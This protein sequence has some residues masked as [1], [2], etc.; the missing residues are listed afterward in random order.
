MSVRDRLNFTPRA[1]MRASWSTCEYT[2]GRF[3]GV[4]KEAGDDDSWL[5]HCERALGHC[6]ATRK[7]ALACARERIAKEIRGHPERLG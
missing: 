5:W 2:P 4:I 3:T 6:H 7:E 1:A